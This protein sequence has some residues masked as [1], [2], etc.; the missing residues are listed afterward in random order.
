MLNI[1]QRRSPRR[2]LELPIRVFGTDFQ[3][4]DFVEDAA[5]LVVSR[6][7]AKIRLNLPSVKVCTVIGNSQLE[8]PHPNRL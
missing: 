1:G 4:R 3:G 6:H 8:V 2:A 5:T 7:G